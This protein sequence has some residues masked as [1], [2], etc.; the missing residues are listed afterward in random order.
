MVDTAPLRESPA[1]RRIWAG[2]GLSAIGGQMTNYAVLLQVFLLTHRSL[3]V[4]LVGLAIAAP[5]IV[6]SLGAGPW[7]D[8][9]DRRRT[10]LTCTGI[11][12]GVSAALA[13][14]AFAHLDRLWLLY[15]LVAVQ[16]SVGGVSAPARRTFMPM[17]LPKD[18]LAAGA[19]LQMLTMHGSATIGPALA[20]LLTAAAGLRVCYVVD[21]VSFA[22]ALYGVARL[23]RAL[24]RPAATAG[25][26]M[27]AAVEG[28]RFIHQQRPV[29]GA[30]VADMSAAF[31][32][33]PIALFPAINAARFGGD[34]TTLGLMTTAVATGG[35]L[36][37]SL[38]GPASRLR[39]RGLGILAA[40]TVW[41]LGIVAFGFADSFW[42]AA[43]SLLVAGAGDSTAVVLRTAVVQELTPDE[44]RGRVSAAEFAAGAGVAQLGNLRAGALASLTSPGVAAVSGGLSAVAGAVLIGTLVPA[45]VT[46]DRSPTAAAA[47]RPS[48]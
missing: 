10:V 18:Q 14:Q 6:V 5:T 28:F 41:G 20:G 4:G 47:N 26:G 13:V 43:L 19:A 37:A 35:I 27:R 36:G 38:S 15:L 2:N 22:F 24:P 9:I 23:P 42:L 46:L 31:L 16:A 29:L 8:R 44:L 1:Y 32:A 25:R 40:G 3:A 30:I 33:M 12:V 17:L 45:L 34:P 21:A 48:G 39:R 11:Q 7:I